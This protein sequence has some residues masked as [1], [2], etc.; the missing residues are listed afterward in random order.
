M[1]W[2]P[3]TTDFKPEPQ[4]LHDATSQMSHVGFAVERRRA[5]DVAYFPL[6]FE[7]LIYP[8][9]DV[10]ASPLCSS[11]VFHFFRA[12]RAWQLRRLRFLSFVLA[13]LF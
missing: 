3:N 2:A 8:S 9:D 10:D 11:Y 1:A 12:I 4:I 6:F 5:F 13:G 7:L